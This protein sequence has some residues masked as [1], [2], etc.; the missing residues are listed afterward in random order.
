MFSKKTAFEFMLSEKRPKSLLA[1]LFN[2]VYAD[3]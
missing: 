2:V 3:L 1:E